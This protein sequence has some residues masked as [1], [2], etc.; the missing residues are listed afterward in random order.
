M[1]RIII[2]FFVAFLGGCISYKVDINYEENIQNEFQEKWRIRYKQ[3][4]CRLLLFSDR[5]NK[6]PFNVKETKNLKLNTIFDSIVNIPK[7]TFYGV[8]FSSDRLEVN[9]NNYTF[10]L[11]VSDTFQVIKI[12]NIK[13]NTLN[14]IFSNNYIS[15]E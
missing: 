15:G 11:N 12:I 7:D 9:I 8:C 2:F 10:K 3:N 4:D 1:K 6:I 5:F 13:N 14:V